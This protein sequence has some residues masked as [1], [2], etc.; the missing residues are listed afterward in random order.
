MNKLQQI[1]AQFGAFLSR[2]MKAVI[3]ALVLCL[4]MQQCTISSL[5]RELAFVKQ[6][7]EQ[8]VVIGQQQSETDSTIVYGEARGEGEVLVPDIPYAVEEDHV[9]TNSHGIPTWLSTTMTLLILVGGYCFVAWQF[10]FFPFSLR[11]KGRVWQ[12]LQGRVVFSVDIRNNMRVSVVVADAMIE[13]MDTK[14]TRKFKVP[15]ADFPLT[16]AKGTRHTVNISLQKVMEKDASLMNFRAIRASL[17]A[18]GRQTH[19]MPV[20]VKWKK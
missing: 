17:T 13:F 1:L 6:K 19:T 2:H 20:G 15:V 16:M 10:G 12:D 4:V 18:N 3:I 11:V 7:Y 9:S 8:P 5:R 14:G